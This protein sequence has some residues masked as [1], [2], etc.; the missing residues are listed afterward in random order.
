M[1]VV[2]LSVSM[3][4]TAILLACVATVTV[5]TLNS[6]RTMNSRTSSSAD[7]RIGLESVSRT[8]RTAAV[9]SGEAAA[10][11]VATNTA[12]T[13]Y[14]Q[15]NR[16][17]ALTFGGSVVPSRIE[18]SQSNG[19]LREAFTPAR[20]IVGSSPTRFA[21]DTGRTTKCVLRTDTGTVQFTY[22]GSAVAS[23]QLLPLVLDKIQSV[24]LDLTV[25]DPDNRD[26]GGVGMKTRT[27]LDNVVLLSGGSV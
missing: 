6:V 14:S 25:I 19:C 22:Y 23:A 18:Y 17:G 8:L 16:T 9:P 2:E 1:T 7:G 20:V 11:T 10:V 12:L 5:T 3:I 27:T 21:W 13:F 15:V 4:I 26:A 24:Q